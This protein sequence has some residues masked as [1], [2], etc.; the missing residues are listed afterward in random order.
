MMAADAASDQGGRQPRSGVSESPLEGC[1]D[2]PDVL[3]GGDQR[4]AEGDRFTNRAYDQPVVVCP[5]EQ[6]IVE[7]THAFSPFEDRRMPRGASAHSG[8]DAA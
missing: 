5:L 7:D 3:L 2:V 6:M 1:G 8:R 4:R